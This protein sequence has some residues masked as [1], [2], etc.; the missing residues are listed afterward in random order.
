S[1][2]LRGKAPFR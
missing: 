1:I 2:V